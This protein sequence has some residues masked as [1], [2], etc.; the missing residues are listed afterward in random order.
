[1]QLFK[2]NYDTKN[3]GHSERLFARHFNIKVI[4]IAITSV[5]FGLAVNF[6][7][8][9]ERES[10]EQLR[11]TTISLVNLLVQEG[12][13]NKAKADDLLNQANKDL[14]TDKEKNALTDVGDDQA[15]IV[16]KQSDKKLPAFHT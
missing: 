16:K 11:S 1:M 7:N 8:A 14:V 15:T 13:L 4:V 2:K 6:A 5:T 10:L 12:L 9:A 3:I